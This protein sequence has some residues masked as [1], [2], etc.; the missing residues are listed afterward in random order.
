MQ[1][2]NNNDYHNND[3]C[4]NE[5]IIGSA[6]EHRGTVE[7]KLLPPLQKT[8][9]YFVKRTVFLQLCVSIK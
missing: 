1:C 5:I 8:K 9:N 4:V 3:Y 6:F 2:R 7:T